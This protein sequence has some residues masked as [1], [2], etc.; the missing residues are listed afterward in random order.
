MPAEWKN[1][2]L[3]VKAPKVVLEP[4]EP[5]ALV[6]VKS[7]ISTCSG[8]T[9]ADDRDRAIFLVLLD[10]GLRAQELC[11]V[12]LE[13]ADLNTGGHHCPVRQGRKD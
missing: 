11:D 3:K 9:V 7:L 10:T 4:L 1:P 2:M 6:D 12:N 13:D 5:V 8:G